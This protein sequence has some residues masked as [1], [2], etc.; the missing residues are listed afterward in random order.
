MPN[1]VRD[2]PDIEELKSTLEGMGA[3]YV[4]TD[5]FIRTPEMK[6]FMKTISKA[7]LA[8]NCVGGKSAVREKKKKI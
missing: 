7:K 4:I 3:T 6:E 1:I 8:F 2:R 5:K